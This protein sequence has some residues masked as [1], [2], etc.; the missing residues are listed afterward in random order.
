M[1]IHDNRRDSA[2]EA[3]QQAI[4]LSTLIVSAAIALWLLI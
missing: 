3:T 1:T 4:W 2:S